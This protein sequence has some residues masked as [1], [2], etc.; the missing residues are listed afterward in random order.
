MIDFT[1]IVSVTGI[2]VILH[3]AATLNYSR[4]PLVAQAI[5]HVPDEVLDF[6]LLVYSQLQLRC[7]A[8]D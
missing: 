6:G 4:A 5:H 3:L 2:V 1:R 7:L 8:F